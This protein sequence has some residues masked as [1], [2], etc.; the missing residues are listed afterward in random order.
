MPS[1]LQQNVAI[2]EPSIF[3]DA[4]NPVLLGVAATYPAVFPLAFPLNYQDA[5]VTLPIF[6]FGYN[7]LFG[8]ISS[9]QPM[10]FAAYFASDYS[11][12]ANQ[13]L[14]RFDTSNAINS[15]PDALLAGQEVIEVSVPISGPYLFFAI[16]NTGANPMTYFNIY[17]GLRTV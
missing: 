12:I 13:V 17:L 15:W 10:A 1:E 11:A 16:D 14:N 7:E 3:I 8:M 2:R 6:T 4:R 5:F 9:D